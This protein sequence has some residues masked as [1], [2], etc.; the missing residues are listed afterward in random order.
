MRFART[1]LLLLGALVWLAPACGRDELPLSNGGSAG[2]GVG[3]TVA[4]A[5]AAGATAGGTGGGAG[6][7][8]DAS[9]ASATVDAS[10]DASTDALTDAASD[11]LADA[12]AA[13]V[14]MPE[15]QLVDANPSSAT[16]QQ[17]LSPSYFRGQVSAW[18]FGHST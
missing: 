7:V 18:Y 9:D 16:Y 5:G 10:L 15:F 12:D 1:A 6:T 2:S 8:P 17:T 3:G 13:P 4:Q 14:L 11:V